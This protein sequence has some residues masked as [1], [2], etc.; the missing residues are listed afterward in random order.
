VLEQSE[1]PGTREAESL[2]GQ[3]ALLA[4]KNRQLVAE[5]AAA[6]RQLQRGDNVPSAAIQQ[7]NC[8]PACLSASPPMPSGLS[9]RSPCCVSES[10]L[11]HLCVPGHLS[12]SS[13]MHAPVHQ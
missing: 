5:L 11:V 1:A 4:D 9:T 10:S 12:G 13:F 2:R 3:V 6:R 8:R 7:V